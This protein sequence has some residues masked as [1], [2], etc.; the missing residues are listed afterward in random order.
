MRMNTRLRFQ[1][2]RVVVRKFREGEA[3]ERLVQKK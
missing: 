2:A 3:K 1:R